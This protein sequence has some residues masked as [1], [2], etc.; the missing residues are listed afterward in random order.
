[1]NKTPSVTIGIP[2]YNGA[3][4]IQATAESVLGQTYRDLELLIVDNAS[5]DSTQSVCEALASDDSRVR[6]VRNETNIGQNAN[7]T[8]VFQ[9]ATGTYFRWMGDDDWLEP[10]YV[11]EC[12]AALDGAPEASL[13]STYQAHVKPDGEELYAE[14]TGRRPISDDPI[15]RLQVL[16]NLLTGS[17]L[18]ID[19]IYCLIR[20][21]HIPGPSPIRR[22]RFGDET[23]ACELALA[24]SFVHVPRKLAFRSWA[25]L[26]KGRKATAQ[27]TGTSASGIKSWTN[28]ASQRLIMMRIVAGKVITQPGLSIT[29]RVR[30]LAVIGAFGVK[31]ATIR[32]WRY[33][34]KRIPGRN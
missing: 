28:A 14:Y 15:V 13:V 7:F 23:L 34:A 12:V 6:Y 26:P 24:G 3:A 16:L 20:R 29:Q 32:V 11:E 2:V 30:G 33:V 27:Y 9:E 25:P 21:S 22:I 18:W 17:A 31:K 1:M 19:P 5:T 8:K 4:S 10:S